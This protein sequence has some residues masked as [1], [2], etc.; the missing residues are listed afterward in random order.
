M[1]R[2]MPFIVLISILVVGL[3][4]HGMIVGQDETPTPTSTSPPTETATETT[5]STA[6]ETTTSTL[7]PTLT[8]T[9][10]D[11]PTATETA[12]FTP[13]AETETATP[14]ETV[15]ETATG[16]PTT[17]ATV[18]TPTATVTPPPVTVAPTGLTRVFFFQGLADTNVDIYANGL[19]LG[20]NV[21]TGRMLGPFALLDGTAV[22][23]LVYPAGNLGQPTLINTLAFEPGSTVLVVAFNGPGGVPMLAVYRLDTVPGQ[24]QL[25]A[26]NAS[27][28]PALD[29]VT[30]SGP[31]S[32][33]AP[34][35]STQITVAPG[36]TASLADATGKRSA[37]TSM[38]LS[39]LAPDEVYLQIAVGSVTNGTYRVIT[40]A[41]DLS[42]LTTVTP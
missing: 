29:V 9:T 38:T 32:S 41:I 27:D 35:F 7:P 39:A 3:T 42:S 21:E 22:T 34:G 26:I 16:S 2:I 14:T 19:Q 10:T 20:G 31:A 28:A 1:R 33:V 8:E 4:T 36:N 24:S 11:L 25:I 40:Q 18:E 37:Q 23:M 5:T 6:T 13:T 30:S 17:T 12:P 15:T